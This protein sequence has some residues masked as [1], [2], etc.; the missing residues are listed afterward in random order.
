MSGFKTVV[1]FP[2]TPSHVMGKYVEWKYTSPNKEYNDV[3]FMTWKH[4]P[5]Y[6]HMCLY[7]VIDYKE[8]EDE[9]FHSKGVD[10]YLEKRIT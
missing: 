9:G 7:N 6:E 1:G 2:P 8:W 3:Y 5:G 4:I 10:I